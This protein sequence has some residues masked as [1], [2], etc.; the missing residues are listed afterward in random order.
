MCAVIL[1][2]LL[3]VYCRTNEIY[4]CLIYVKLSCFAFFLFQTKTS[5]TCADALMSIPFITF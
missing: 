2:H 3:F 4:W 1:N 5:G